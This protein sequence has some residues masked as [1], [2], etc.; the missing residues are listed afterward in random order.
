MRIKIQNMDMQ[1]RGSEVSKIN[2][3]YRIEQSDE[4]L[5]GTGSLDIN[6][7][8]YDGNI[9]SLEQ[10]CKDHLL[11]NIDVMDYEIRST[12]M[13]YDK[14][15][16]DSVQV[17]FRANKPNREL[18]IRG[19]FDLSADEYQTDPSVESLEDFAKEFIRG[20]VDKS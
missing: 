11:D 4:D 3:L 16:I 2:V 14:N 6:K 5:S 18:S 17:I 12:N 1:Y 20:E 15:E 13:V 8:D 7:D 10:A 19:N 9:E